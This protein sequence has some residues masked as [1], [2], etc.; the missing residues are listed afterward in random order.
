MHI[1]Y[2]GHACFVSPFVFFEDNF[3]SYFVESCLKPT[4]GVADEG[5][6]D[7]TI[8][9]ELNE[10]LKEMGFNVGTRKRLQRLQ[11]RNVQFKQT[12]QTEEHYE[13][14]EEQEDIYSMGPPPS[15]PQRVI[16]I[17]FEHKWDT[18]IEPLKRCIFENFRCRFRPI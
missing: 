18:R 1:A 14:I 2:T 11:R 10:D 9:D 4:Y 3:A 15:L 8:L 16:T 7:T 17:L 6:T 12:V 13:D 5:I